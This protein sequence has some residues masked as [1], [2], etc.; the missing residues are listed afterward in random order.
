MGVEDRKKEVASM[1]VIRQGFGERWGNV[2]GLERGV[3]CRKDRRGKGHFGRLV[4][5]KQS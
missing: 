2:L 3:K 5:Q 4:Q 1:D